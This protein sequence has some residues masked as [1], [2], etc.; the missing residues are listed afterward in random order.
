MLLQMVYRILQTLKKCIKSILTMKKICLFA[1]IFLF[2]YRSKS[3]PSLISSFEFL[4]YLNSDECNIS[5]I[6][7]FLN[8]FILFR[9]GNAD[10][11]TSYAITNQE[12]FSDLLL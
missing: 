4:R 9:L 7:I 12:N 1:S 10:Y 11:Y 6:D 5:N 2:Y 3:L 8:K